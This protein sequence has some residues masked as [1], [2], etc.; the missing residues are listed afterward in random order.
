MRRNCTL[1]SDYK[2]KVAQLYAR[3]GEEGP[4]GR[5]PKDQDWNCSAWTRPEIG[6]MINGRTLWESSPHVAYSGT[7]LGAMFTT[8]WHMLTRLPQ[9]AEIVGPRPLL[10]A[11]RAK[12]LEDELVRSELIKSTPGNWLQIFPNLKAW[13]H[14]EGAISANWWTEQMFWLMWMNKDLTFL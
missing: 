11:K 4:E 10:L 2:L 9:L 7:E 12:Y 8:R 1:E 13:S 6:L 5:H 14:A 3:F